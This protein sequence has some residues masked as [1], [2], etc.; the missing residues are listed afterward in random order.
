MRR[1]AI[2]HWVTP[3]SLLATVLWLAASALFSM[4]V[5]RIAS[6]DVTYGPL[7]AVA[8]MMMWFYVTA[9]VVVLGPS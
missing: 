1:R 5:G 7:G 6:Y 4:Y 3:G 9:Y 2:W 8:G